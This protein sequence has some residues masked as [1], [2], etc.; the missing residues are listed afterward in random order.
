MSFFSSDPASDGMSQTSDQ[1]DPS[2]S[3][4]AMNLESS[5]PVANSSSPAAYAGDQDNSDQDIPG[6]GEDT[7]YTSQ[8]N[9]A[10]YAAGAS[11]QASSA[12]GAALPFNQAAAQGMMPP[13]PHPSQQPQVP[14][15]QDGLPAE[16]MATAT[17]NPYIMVYQPHTD[18]HV[19]PGLG[20]SLMQT[21][22]AL[23]LPQHSLTISPPRRPV[24]LQ[25]I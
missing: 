20:K 1:I 5:S 10:A 8:N 16:A 3:D 12:D 24:P 18:W 23:S 6:L 13:P 15:P 25:W 21:Y 7:I 22:I 19:I 17:F 9:M 14:P 4:S 11:G 2:L